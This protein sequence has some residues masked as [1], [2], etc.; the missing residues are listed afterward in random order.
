MYLKKQELPT[1]QIILKISFGVVNGNLGGKWGSGDD[2]VNF[3]LF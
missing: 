2:L 3:T 1:I